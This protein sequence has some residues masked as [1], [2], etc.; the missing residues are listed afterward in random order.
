MNA[1]VP[2]KQATAVARPA[3]NLF[4]AFQ[5]EVDRLFD[6][7]AP[8]FTTGRGLTDVKCRMDMAETKDGLELTA[9]LPG[10]DEK[11]VEVTVA[12]GV[13]TLRGEKRF[14]SEEKD[15]NYHFVER[16][17]GGFARSVQ[18]PDGVKAEAIKATLN[19]GV[20]KVT[21]PMAAKAE[22]KKIAVQAAA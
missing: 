2:V 4:G 21:I 19:K 16:G 15:K 14:E 22:P 1:Q 12:D 17:Y 6:D 11:D 20:L 3:Y 5:R 7:F 13:L 18:L 9:E 8:T 10:I